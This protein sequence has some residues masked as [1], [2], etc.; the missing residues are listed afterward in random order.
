MIACPPP[1]FSPRKPGLLLPPGATDCHAH[2]FG[3]AGRF[4]YAEPRSYTPPDCLLA[5]YRHMLAT[6][7]VERAVLVQPSVYGTDNRNHLEALAEA[8]PAFRMVAVLDEAVGDGELARLNEAGVRGVRFNLVTKGG[9]PLDGLE[10][11]A[12]RLAPLGWHL[13]LF[14]EIGTFAMIESR[15]AALPA[16]IV[17]DHMGGATPGQGLHHPGFQA[18]LRLVRGG[19]TWVKLSGAYRVS[20][21]PEPPF[22]DVVPI[23]R[24]LIE[25]GPERMV[26][27]SDWPHPI[28]ADRPMPNDGDL[29]ELLA[30]WAPD[31]AQ[32]RRIL[33]DNPARLY[34]FE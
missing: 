10:R 31:E 5:Q 32:R 1:D 26:W 24:A 14:V 27:G 18:L 29:V 9:I 12:L 30:D 3:P 15:L 33:V 13:Q 22:S 25:A 16:P 17:V 19:N 20:A 23:A 8:G 28:V 6:V 2:V 11:M 21:Q 7:G 34:G 4:P